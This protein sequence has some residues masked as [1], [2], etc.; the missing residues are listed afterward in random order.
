MCRHDDEARAGVAEF[1]GFSGNRL[2]Q[3]RHAK[4]LHIQRQRGPERTAR[5]HSNDADFDTAGV[6][7]RRRMNV[8]PVDSLARLGIKKIR[9]EERKRRLCG[10]GLQRSAR[11]I[12]RVLSGAGSIGRTK[13]ELVIAYRESGVAEG[14]VRV[15]DDSAFT[16]IRLDA[17]LERVAR[18]EQDDVATVGLSRRAQIVD[19]SSKD[20][21]AAAAVSLH[22]ITMEIGGADN[23]Q[24]ERRF[25]LHADRRADTF[26]YTGSKGE[27][28]EQ[29]ANRTHRR[30]QGHRKS[31][32]VARICR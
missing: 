29:R 30:R 4:T 24:R 32:H 15:D 26:G 13:V 7:Q 23:G 20:A 17:T 21:E 8:G 12:S 10:A 6:N 5:H 25:S 9:R 16:E 28:G 22:E 1:C 19:V 3:R 18:I 14:V 31:T 2:G 27:E 11:V